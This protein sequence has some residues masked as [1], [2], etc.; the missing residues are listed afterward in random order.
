MP[1]FLV[2]YLIYHLIVTTIYTTLCEKLDHSFIFYFWGF[3]KTTRV[4]EYPPP[5]TEPNSRVLSDVR[6][7]VSGKKVTEPPIMDTGHRY[8]IM[9]LFTLIPQV[10]QKSFT[11]RVFCFNFC[12]CAFSVPCVRCP[13]SNSPVSDVR[14]LESQNR[15]GVFCNP[16]YK[17]Y[18]LLSKFNKMHLQNITNNRYEKNVF[19]N[20]KIKEFNPSCIEVYLFNV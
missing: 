9:Y 1:H 15:G 19:V 11:V 13:M 20:K 18:K 17:Y 16:D 8:L 12:L 14:R 2:F 10:Y 3:V 6:C 7:P 4:T 5:G